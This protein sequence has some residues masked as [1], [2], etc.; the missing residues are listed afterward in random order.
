MY[1]PPDGIGP[2]QAAY[3]LDRAHRQ[4]SS[5]VASI[6]EAAEKGALDARPPDDEAWTV[7]DTQGPQGWAGLDPVTQ[8]VA[9]LTGGPQQSFTAS[10]KSVGAG[11]EA[12][13]RAVRLR[14]RH[15]ELGRRRPGSCSARG[16]GCLGGLFVLGGGILALVIA[17]R[18]TS[19]D[20]SIIALIPGAA[21]G[22]RGAGA[23][24]RR[25][26][27]GAPRPAGTCGRGSAASTGCCRRP[28]SQNRFDFSGREDLYTQYIPWAVAF[29]CA[30]EWAAK[31]RIETGAEPPVPAYFPGYAG[32]HTGNYT[33]QMVNRLLLDRGQRHLGVRRDPDLVVLRRRRRRRVLRRRRWRRRGRWLLVSVLVHNADQRASYHRTGDPMTGLIIVG[34]IVLALIGFGVTGFNKLRTSDV[35]AQEALGG[36]DVQLTRRADLIPNLVDTV[37]GYAAHEREVFEEITKARS[38]VQAAAAGSDVPAK[39]AADAALQGAL[40]RLNAVAEA[41]PDL[42]ANTNFLDLQKQLAETENQISFARQYYNDAV[43]KLNTLVAHHP[44]DVLRRHR[45]R[46]RPRVLRGARRLHRGPAGGVLTAEPFASVERAR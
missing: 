34:V 31:Y 19:F 35:G 11:Q 38:Q 1:A 17:V 32:S 21:R 9:R 8:R 45:R 2:A 25:R 42:K 6:M 43:A 37:K 3:I 36:I 27:P 41:Y 40:I 29:G 16:L 10:P 5:Y 24:D 18:S 23:G 26:A 4:A 28:S 7:T 15:H 12:A 33:D 14:V 20:M 30:D 46:A 22:R 44:V 39:A 13:E